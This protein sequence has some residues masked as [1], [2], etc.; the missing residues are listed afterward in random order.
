MTQNAGLTITTRSAGET[1]A[2]GELLGRLAASGTCIALFGNL[3]AGK[4]Q[5]A[6]GI[7][8]GARVD[9]PTVVASPTYVLLNI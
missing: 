3:G 7:A 2:L 9:D 6:H 1:R 4:T 5:L 8:L